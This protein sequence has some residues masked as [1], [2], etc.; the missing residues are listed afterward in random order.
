MFFQRLDVNTRFIM[1]AFQV[2]DGAQF[3]EVPIAGLILA[4]KKQVAIGSGLIL[5][6]SIGA[7]SRG[8][9]QLSAD[10]R[11]N[12]ASFGRQIEIDYAEHGAMVG[13]GARAHAILFASL[14]KFR[15]LDRAVENAVFRMNMEMTETG[16][17]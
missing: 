14:D 3:A 1:E 11:F 4:Q 13:D 17:H 6:R 8:E 15:D 9:V 5:G 7:M 16:I 10:N 2:A 12:A